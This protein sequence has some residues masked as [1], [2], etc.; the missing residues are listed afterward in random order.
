MTMGQEAPATLDPTRG[1]GSSWMGPSVFAIALLARVVF[2]F[3]V[4]ST[5]AAQTG[6]NQ[7]SDG[8]EDIARNLMN[9]H[10]FRLKEGFAQ[11]TLRVPGYSGFL[12]LV[13]ELFGE[14]LWVVQLIQSFFGALSAWLIANL[15]RRTF[16]ARAGWVAGLCWAFYPGDLV[17]CARYLA[18]P[19][20]ILILLLAISA[21][22]RL[23][24][25]P[26]MGWAALCGGLL[27]L[28]AQV[29]ESN[30]LL[31]LAIV[32]ALL[33]TRRFWRPAWVA[34]R[35][36]VA[37]LAPVVVICAPWVIRGHQLTGKW[38]F[39]STLGGAGLIDGYFVTT[40]LESG[41][42][43]T[44]RYYLYQSRKF[45]AETARENDIGLDPDDN[46]SGV[47][48]TPIDEWRMDRLLKD[49]FKRRTAADPLGFA[50]RSLIGLAR[51]WYMGPT[52]SVSWRA[53]LI[54]APLLGLA[55]IGVL[56]AWG[57][58]SAAIWPWLAVIGYFNTLN[59][60][61]DPL[62][63]YSLSAIPFV[64]LLVGAAVA[65]RRARATGE[66]CPAE[67]GHAVAGAGE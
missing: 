49:E 9:G 25:T 3:F 2:V 47:F 41:E 65:S 7:S 5:L 29:K 37:L 61:I 6:L 28:S 62:V 34:A 10:G 60:I 58:R 11:T 36:S 12:W 22:M 17:A 42:G 64:C 38:F 31:P 63:R 39:P 1:P 19:L 33:T 56:R 13:F 67:T 15:A 20:S 4:F 50:R 26:T 45:L 55:L 51:F 66:L 30:C 48:R 24:R 16:D 43:K 18:E 44:V 35:L 14:R 53:G 32:L 8:Y 57:A 46:F 27:G 21:Y 23:L 40:G 52:P 59:A 54:H